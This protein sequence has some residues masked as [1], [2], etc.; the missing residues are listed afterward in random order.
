M[1]IILWVIGAAVGMFNG[2]MCEI[3]EKK[4]GHISQLS[5][6]LGGIWYILLLNGTI[7]VSLELFGHSFGNPAFLWAGI[8]GFGLSVQ[9]ILSSKE[10]L[11]G[12]IAIFIGI[13]AAAFIKPYANVILGTV[14]GF[15]FIIPALI[16]RKNYRKQE[17]ENV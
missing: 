15:S 10:W 11:L 13:I 3:R 2:L 17:K 12:G 14:I 8:F 1:W 6:Q 7:W 5:K 9:G 4:T 16:S